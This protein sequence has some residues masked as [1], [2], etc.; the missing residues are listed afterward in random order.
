MFNPILERPTA[1]TPVPPV[2]PH[3][4][5]E[6]MDVNWKGIAAVVFCFWVWYFISF[7]P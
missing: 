3:S 5:P 6:R 4:Q 2:L 1:P 7:N